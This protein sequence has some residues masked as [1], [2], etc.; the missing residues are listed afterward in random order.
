MIAREIA[1]ASVGRN[2][3]TVGFIC[4]VAALL[5]GMMT[6]SGADAFFKLVYPASWILMTAGAFAELRHRSASPLKTCRFYV[7][8]TASV[9]P[10]LGPLAVFGLIYTCPENGREGQAGLSGFVSPIFRL[11]ADLLLLFSLIMILFLLFAVVTG[12]NDP[13]FR[14]K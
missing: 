11:R 9:F 6:L 2:A 4:H 7:A 8:A 10:L 13:Y 5:V 14:R 12:T 1:A 3:L